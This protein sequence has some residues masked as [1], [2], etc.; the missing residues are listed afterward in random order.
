[1]G[2]FLPLLLASAAPGI[3]QAG[4]S[5]IG[6]RARNKRLNAATSAYDNSLGDYMSADISKNAF[7]NI[8][9]PFEDLTVNQQQAEF[10]MDNLAQNTAN[11]MGAFKAS[12]GGSGAAAFA[13][14]LAN[15]Q[16]NATRQISADIGGQEAR[17]NMT[18]ANAELGIQNR[19]AQGA[20]TAMMREFD[21][22][23]TRVGMDQAE[24]A[25]AYD[26]KNMAYQ[27]RMNAFGNV[28]GGISNNA[29]ALADA[30]T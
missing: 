16:A 20:D 1:M 12:M 15:N 21:R 28:A 3:I 10:Q 17:N 18:M 30:L 23:G 7:E 14:A 6:G 27:A 13:Q 22:L 25:G 24:L 29:T 19:A 26:A 9:N 11:T 2:A 5:F 4:A 8:Q